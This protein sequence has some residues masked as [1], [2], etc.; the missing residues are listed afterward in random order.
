MLNQLFA[1]VG[2]VVRTGLESLKQKL[3]ALTRPTTAAV[4]AST[5]P[6]MTRTKSEL[7]AENA[8]LRQQLV[9]LRR[10]IK[11]PKITARDRW[12]LV[13][14]ARQVRHWKQALL[15]VQPDTL[16]RWHRDLFTWVWRRKS[17]AN[18]GRKQ[19]AETTVALIKQMLRE[20]RLWGAERVR[21]GLLKLGIHVSKR[22][23]QRY[24]HEGQP[25]RGGN[26]NWRTFIHN[27]ADEIWACA[28]LQVP[29]VLF[30]NLF[31][32]FLVE[33]GSRKVVHVGVTRHPT[34]QWVAQ[35][36]REATPFGTAP[37]YLIRDNDSKFGATIDRV[38]A[39]VGIQGLRTPFQA[40][41]ANAFVERFIGSVR[42]ECLDHLLVLGENHLVRVVN[43][44]VQYFN[45]VRP[46]QGIHQQLPA[47]PVLPVPPSTG[48]ILS[49][50]ILGGL[51]HRYQW[52]A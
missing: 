31:C 43:A 49:V 21:G 40:S 30:R 47:N 26:Q 18:T 48:K 34:E 19:I 29:D 35:Q 25:S 3:S 12:F 10:S 39:G 2:R 41:K 38:A 20:N 16:L 44:Y 28:F 33:V 5:P 46:H 15:L 24:K 37:K 42:R 51:H 11:R 32:F 4:A 6:D 1:C 14:L 7:I 13:L 50:P 52:A 17:K 23:I 36:L 45:N 9:V 27:H 22:T 8:L